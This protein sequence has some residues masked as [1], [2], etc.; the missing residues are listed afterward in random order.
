MAH[1]CWKYHYQVVWFPLR[2]DRPLQGVILAKVSQCFWWFN[3]HEYLLQGSRKSPCDQIR[4]TCQWHRGAAENHHQFPWLSSGRSS[5]E[6]HNGTQG[7]MVPPSPQSMSQANFFIHL[8]CSLF[9]L[10]WLTI[11]YLIKSW[12]C[13]RIYHRK[14]VWRKSML[15]T[16][17]TRPTWLTKSSGGRTKSTRF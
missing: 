16:T 2:V 8:D 4:P 14:K 15:F 13:C 5:N 17:K 1:L 12:N 9:C 11:K 6:L 7:G 3:C 10:L